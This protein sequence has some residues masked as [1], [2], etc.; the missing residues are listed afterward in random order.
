MVP[1]NYKDRS[2]C[3]VG[4]GFVGVTLGA[5]MADCGFYVSGIE[6][7]DEVIEML[8]KGEPH[9][10]EPG[11]A[12]LLRRVIKQGR[13]NV[14]KHIPNDISARVYFI[15]VGTPLGKDGR[16]RTDMIENVTREVAQHLQDGD[17]VILRSTV[18]LG[19]TRELVLPILEKSGKHFDLAFCPERT[20]EGYAMSELRQL[21]QIVGGLNLHSSIRA[22]QL[23]QF[24]TPSVVQVSD[25]ETAEMIKLVDNSHRDVYL[26]YGNEVARMCDAMGISATEVIQMGRLGYPRTNVYMPGPVGGP[27]LEKDP[28]ILAEGLEEFGVVPEISQAARLVNERQPSE[29]ASF[30]AKT[31]KR[32]AGFPK[33]PIISLLGIAFKGRPETD[34]L[35][36]TMARPIFHEIKK[37]FPDAEF[38][39]FDPVVSRKAIQEFGLEPCEKLEDAFQESHLVL[40]LNN[41]LLF[42]KMNLEGLALNLARPALIYDFWSNFSG[43]EISMP[44]KVS[45]MALGSHGRAV[46][47]F[48]YEQKIS[49]DRRHRISRVGAR[50]ASRERRAPRARA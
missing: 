30:L 22:A 39:G 16:V 49:R 46:H 34:D 44:D 25:L 26:A 19:L 12:D 50:K 3:I 18:K 4:L 5:V 43:R 20:V 47:P 13:F 45:Y 9:F 2:V 15:T 36:G 23:F 24:I 37:Q 14:S 27:C 35:R 28:H 7:R 8:K 6:I 32:L 48:V 31:L 29:V 21:P 17:M 11:L 1:E 42:S 41:H 33:N 38:R 10:H 40:I